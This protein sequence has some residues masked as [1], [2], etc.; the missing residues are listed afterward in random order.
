MNNV[1]LSV[2]AEVDKVLSE[3]EISQRHSYFQ[4]KYFL[5]GKEPTVQ[6][7]M[8][9]CLREMKNRNDTTKNIELETEELKDKLELLDISV[10]RIR[11]DME[12]IQIT[13]QVSN[14]LYMRECE[15][16]IRQFG[17]QKKS[18]EQNIKEI[19]ERKKSIS[20]ECRFFLETYKNLLKIEP[21]KHFDDLEAQK[22][23]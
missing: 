21:L 9:Q 14:N 23:Y 8:W 17:R 15:I 7:K 18:L 20:E 13:D 22:Q 12:N 6:S 19:E 16:K 3:Q 10:E 4:L 5:I 11:H 1:E 2:Y